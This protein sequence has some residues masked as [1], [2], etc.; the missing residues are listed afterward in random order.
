MSELTIRIGEKYIRWSDTT[1]TPTQ[2]LDDITLYYLTRTF[3][4][5]LTH[6][7]AAPPSRYALP[8]TQPDLP[9]IK[10][11]G[12]PVGYSLF[13][14]EITPFLPEWAE[15]HVNLVWSAKH[16]KVSAGLSEG[17][18]K[19]K[20]QLVGEEKYGDEL[21]LTFRVDTLPL[22]NNPSC[23]GRICRRS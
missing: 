4:T 3:A 12:K 6:Y 17:G 1:P 11:T 8:E 20:G 23:S 7:W 21:A 15:G 9:A 10:K 13:K 5:S 2:I 19:G 22:W 14:K 18:Q 16:D